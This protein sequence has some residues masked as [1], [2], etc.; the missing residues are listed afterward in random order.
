M[1][2]L[3]CVL[4]SSNRFLSNTAFRGCSHFGFVCLSVDP[5]PP[6]KL[7]GTVFLQHFYRKVHLL[8]LLG[9]VDF[10]LG[11]SIQWRGTVPP[12]AW[13]C[14]GRTG[15]IRRARFWNIIDQS[16]PNPTIRANGPPCICRNRAPNSTI[17][18]NQQS[19][20]RS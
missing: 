9:W 7:C 6:I 20:G 10:E 3:A 12:S 5:L 11:C 16:Q 2:V 1:Y 18:V 15:F 8:G 14:L 4:P 17:A 13:F 19:V